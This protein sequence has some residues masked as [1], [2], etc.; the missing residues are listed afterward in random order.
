MKTVT[1]TKCRAHGHAELQLTYDSARLLDAD[2]QWFAGVLEGMVQSGSR[3]EIGQSLQVGWSVAW[4]TGLSSGVLGFE[5]PDMRSMPIVRQAGLTNSLGHLRLQKDTLE[6][7]LPPDALSFPSLLQS[8]LICSRVQSS[9]TFFMD[10]SSS[11]DADCGWFIGCCD[12]NHDHNQLS[13]L[14]KVS[15]YEAVAR[16]CGGAL[17]YL[18]FPSGSLVVVDELPTFFANG[19]ELEIRPGSYVDTQRRKQV[20]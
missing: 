3:F 15:L 12:E 4:F 9:P 20:G 16:Y 7:V 5:E 11:A 17:P 19:Q 13:E 18:A 8:C 2:A 1:T 14:R 10:R 6:S